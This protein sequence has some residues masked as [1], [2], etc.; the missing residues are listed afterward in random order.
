MKLVY[1]VLYSDVCLGY[2]DKEVLIGIASSDTEVEII[3]NN[4][5][6]I[7][8]NDYYAHQHTRDGNCVFEVKDF[9][10]KYL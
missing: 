9:N 4:Y 2:G 5:N 10:S 6:E 3:K 8:K 7:Y 1:V